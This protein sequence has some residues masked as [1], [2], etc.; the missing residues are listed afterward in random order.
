MKSLSLC[1]PTFNHADHLDRMLV[2][3]TSLPSFAKGDVEIVLSDNASSDATQTVGEQYAARFPGRVN[4]FRNAENVVD[5][6]FGLALSRGTGKFLKLVNDTLLYSEQGLSN[7]LETVRRWEAEQPILFFSN[8]GGTTKEH[9]CSSLDE[10][11]ETI[12]FH[13][14]WIGSFGIWKKDFD[15]LTDFGRASKLK[16]T[17][18]DA[19]CRMMSE[20]KKAVVDTT[21]FATSIPRKAIGG[22]NLAEVFGR[23][24]F[25]ILSEYVK[26][27]ELSSRVFRHEK[28]RMLRYHILPFYLTF[29]PRVHFPKS[30]YLRYLI[31]D[32]WPSLFYW[33]TV[34]FVV[35]AWLVQWVLDLVRG[36]GGA[37]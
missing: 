28:Y 37:Q 17:Q 1:I 22:Y 33:S 15:H 30:G 25:T 12:T 6:N 5:A 2:N 14:T 7:M 35:G 19:L 3:L 34:P 29:S 4:Y 18:V 20:R 21:E 9:I 36:R 23:N 26:S 13:S 10:L 31:Q 32:Y 24:Y 11:F 27:G 16:L 8:Q